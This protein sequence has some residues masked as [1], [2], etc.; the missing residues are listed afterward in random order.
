MPADAAAAAWVLPSIRFCLKSRT[1]ASL[2]MSLQALSVTQTSRLT[3]SGRSNCRQ[4]A[5]L[6][7]AAQASWLRATASGA[8]RCAP[9]RCPGSPVHRCRAGARKRIRLAADARTTPYPTTGLNPD[10]SCNLIDAGSRQLFRAKRRNNQTLSALEPRITVTHQSWYACGS[11]APARTSVTPTCRGRAHAVDSDP[12]LPSG[13]GATVGSTLDRDVHTRF[14]VVFCNVLRRR[15][16]RDNVLDS[17]GVLRRGSRLGRRICIGG[18]WVVVDP[19]G[20]HT[21]HAALHAQPMAGPH[22]HRRGLSA[23]DLRALAIM[24][25]CA[26]WPLRHVRRHRFRCARIAC[27][28]RNRAWLL[29][30]L[31]RRT[32]MADPCLAAAGAT[33]DV[34]LFV[35]TSAGGA[36]LVVLTFQGGLDSQ[37]IS[38][39]RPRK[40]AGI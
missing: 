35:S 3:R 9:S 31:Q 26:I 24:G 18:S 14:N 29:S 27:G 19:M 7:V 32:A 10:R 8:A 38:R 2:T 5:D 21:A 30:R 17:E 37:C 12:A 39:H 16:S 4:A 15:R 6:I 25:R 13:N 34:K 36:C 33:S 11:A 20:T 22:S 40:S 1:C 28:R 23:R